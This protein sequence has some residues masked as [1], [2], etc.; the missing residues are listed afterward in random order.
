MMDNGNEALVPLILA[1]L[2]LA[3]SMGVARLRHRWPLWIQ[4]TARIIS[5][6]ILTILVQ[7]LLGSPLA[8]HYSA[9]YSGKDLW[10]HV[11]EAG[12]WI[13]AAR[14]GVVLVRLFVVLEH[15]PR[16]SQI[17]SDLMAGGIYLATLLAIVNYVFAV[18]IAG[19]VATSGVI[20]IVLGLALQNTLSDVFSG[21]AVGV[22]RPYK[23][24]DLIWVEGGIE[25]HVVQV[26]WRSTHIAT[27]QSTVAV[28]PNSVMAKARLINRSLPDPT[29]GDSIELRL[30]A[31]VLPEL[32]IATLLAAARAA[33]LPLALPAPSVSY[34]G[35]HGDGATYEVSYSVASSALLDKART[36]VLGQIH[37]HLGYAGIA[38]AVA[39]IASS[40]IKRV[41]M[42]ADIL[43]QSD[44]FCMLDPE[45]RKTLASRFK[46]ARME[47]GAAL[48]HEGDKP[49][50]LF[51][52]ASGVVEITKIG[53]AGPHLVHR[54]SP[55]ESLGAI[56]LITGS[57]YTA[58][59]KALTPV[60]VFRVDK[61]DIS[62]AIAAT[63]QLA[64][65]LEALA[66]Q[67]RAVLAR[68]A[69]TDQQQHTE[70]PEELRFR[71]RSFLRH[72][73]SG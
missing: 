25:G 66:E 27:F 17:V 65:G 59:A 62:A 52:I 13:M 73:A 38:L 68:D 33:M 63:P 57:P 4:V 45:G 50:F 9:V 69:A 54:M 71:L 35:L 3:G 21:I 30:D 53:P 29:R 28:V 5:F 43:E 40:G 16:E 61:P 6:A 34:T 67:G 7:R 15:R 14:L 1:T 10:E 2:I 22:E 24:G 36:E 12:W 37:R 51:L 39:G 70:P 49:Q 56:G 46:E 48:F 8:P 11:I 31:L 26:T 18:P 19:L 20:A 42:A 32:C 64:A 47:A 23:A 41:P 58:T 55:G 72:L 60:R 44:L